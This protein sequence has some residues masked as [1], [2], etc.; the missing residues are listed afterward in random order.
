M[1]LTQMDL[2]HAF[3]IITIMILSISLYFCLKKDNYVYWTRNY[4]FHPESLK[5]NNTW[6]NYYNSLKSYAEQGLHSKLI[7]KRF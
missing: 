5:I 7:T 4:K 1:A 2:I 3:F 6:G